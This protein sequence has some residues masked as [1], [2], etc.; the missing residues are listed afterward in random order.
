MKLETIKTWATRLLLSFVLVSIGFAVGKDLT[1][2][3]LR[4]AQS[5]A[6]PAVGS[7]TN[8]AAAPTTRLRAYYM[9]GAIRCTTCNQIERTAKELLDAE[10]GTELAS[11]RITWRQVNFEQEPALAKRY[12]VSASTLVLAQEVDG[13]E[14]AFRTLDEVWTLV[15]KPA[16][17]KAYVR[18]NVREL[19][20]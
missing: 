5:A 6:P 16:D 3:R 7:G 15:G 9:H 4:S 8:E 10:F 17:F 18:R 2:R 19:L 1:L 13:K 11:G 20:P 14:T 12:D